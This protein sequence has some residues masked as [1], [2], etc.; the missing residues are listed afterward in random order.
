MTL[1][2]ILIL[3]PFFFFFF[4]WK[5]WV[6]LRILRNRMSQKYT[7]AFQQ[8]KMTGREMRDSWQ[9]H[10][11]TLRGRALWVRTG[12]VVRK[13]PVHRDSSIPQTNS[14]CFWSIHPSL[15]WDFQPLLL[16]LL[17]LRPNIL[18]VN[19]RM[20][21]KQPW[22]KILES[23]RWRLFFGVFLHNFLFFQSWNSVQ[24]MLVFQ[25]NRLQD[26][27]PRQLGWEGTLTSDKMHL[28]N[29]WSLAFFLFCW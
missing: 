25:E 17:L 23:R 6:S 13:H 11:H 28:E 4:Y 19:S 24:T 9:T 12:E 15:V 16:F 5:C 7:R 1:I 18:P 10:A 27:R 2:F 26:G 3:L 8:T 20:V 14:V 21:L 29:K 22:W